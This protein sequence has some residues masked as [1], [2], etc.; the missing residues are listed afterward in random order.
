MNNR[1]IDQ[2][3]EKTDQDLYWRSLSEDVLSKDN[4]QTYSPY[5]VETK[6]K[7]GSASGSQSFYASPMVVMPPDERTPVLDTLIIPNRWICKIEPVFKHPDT[8]TEIAFE[9]GS[10][11][12]IGPR[13]ILTA[14]HVIENEIRTRGATNKVQW[15]K[16]VKVKVVPGANGAQDEPFGSYVS[17]DFLITQ[18]WSTGQN[19]NNR[20]HDFAIIRLE[21][22]VSS[23]RFSKIN[24]APFGYWSDINFG[25]GTHL[26]TVVPQ[27]FKDK[28]VETAGYPRV[29]PT[30]PAG[31]QWSAKGS[32]VPFPH[33]NPVFIHTMDTEV[34]QSGSPI[35]MD[36]SAT[37]KKYLIGIHNGAITGANGVVNN[38]GVM[39]T[40]DII[41]QVLS[42]RT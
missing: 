13:H 8:G 6:Y 2:Q 3:P 40:S 20:H 17:A 35:W 41:K 42:W 23:K 4:L 36:D 33:D 26:T 27:V 10:G 16:A 32:I 29:A 1:F 30:G 14:A 37:G 21:E 18:P 39:M 31:K 9:P 28:L 19:L 25:G 22:D 7:A 38:F 34:G 12:L 24:N 15:Q 11:L 5:I